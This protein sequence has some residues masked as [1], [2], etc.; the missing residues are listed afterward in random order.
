M[1]QIEVMFLGML[2]FLMHLGINIFL[3]VY[4]N[5]ALRLFS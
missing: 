5:G 4:I 3:Y 2:L 1:K